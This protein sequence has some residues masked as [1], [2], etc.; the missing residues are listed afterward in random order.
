MR[1]NSLP[2]KKTLCRYTPPEVDAIRYQAITTVLP[3]LSRGTRSPLPRT[4]YGKLG[5]A[6][7]PSWV[8]HGHGVL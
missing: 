1:P 4:P 8:F 7:A 3:T 5:R 2:L 6:S